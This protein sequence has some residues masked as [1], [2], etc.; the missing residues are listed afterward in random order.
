MIHCGG[1]RRREPRKILEAC[2]G[3][4]VG[5]EHLFEK[6]AGCFETVYRIVFGRFNFTIP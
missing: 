4:T 5:F 2:E 1:V 6:F 3:K